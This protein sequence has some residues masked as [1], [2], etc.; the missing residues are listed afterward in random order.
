MPGRALVDSIG[1]VT[2]QK[3]RR[4]GGSAWT[5]I[6]RAH[7]PHR[8]VLIA[9]CVAL[10]LAAVGDEAPGYDGPGPFID[11]AFA[12]IVALVRWRFVPLLVLAAS[13]LFLFGGLATPEFASR[14]IRPDHRLDF[15]AG[16]LQM[17]GFAAAAVFAAASA[18]HVRRAAR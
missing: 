13:A 3:P 18:V 16:W 8:R 11:L 2:D 5:A 6:G 1:Q 4:R 7:G 9:T 17:L 10:I 14:L 12:V 15:T